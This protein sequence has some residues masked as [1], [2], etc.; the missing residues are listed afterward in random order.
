MSKRHESDTRLRPDSPSFRP[1]SAPMVHSPPAGPS[2]NLS[3]GIS[4]QKWSPRSRGARTRFN[5]SRTFHMANK[6]SKFN[7]KSTFSPSATPPTDQVGGTVDGA[8]TDLVPKFNPLLADWSALYHPPLHPLQYNLYAPAPFRVR[9]ALEEHQRVADDL[10]IPAKLRDE[11]VERNEA[12]LQVLPTSNLP[13]FVHVY[14][15]LLPLDL[16]PSTSHKF[17]EY[18]YWRYKVVSATDGRT[19]CLLRIG[20]FTLPKEYS[21]QA[22]NKWKRLASAGVVG[23]VEAF[24]TLAFGDHS[25]VVVHE[26][27]PLA[28]PVC[29]VYEVP[30]PEGLMWS[31]AAQ[32]FGAVQAIHKQKLVARI[33]DSKRVLVTSKDRLRIGSCG[34]LDIVDFDEPVDPSQDWKDVGAVLKDIGSTSSGVFNYS[35]DFK[36]FIESLDSG[37]SDV[38]K[39]APHLWRVLDG[40]LS[41]VDE[42]ESQLSTE[43]ENGRLVRLLAKLEFVF[44]RPEYEHDPEW[45]PQGSKYPLRLFKDFVFHQSDD[46]NHPSMDLA[47]TITYLNKLDAGID[48][49]ILLTSHDHKSRII[50]SYKD[51]KLQIE[52]IFRELMAT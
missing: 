3:P 20:G 52:Q 31:L 18:P 23:V 4:G 2:G 22:V 24:T 50:V 51:L 21:L 28:R 5:P 48:E 8:F 25:L 44:D 17:G 7:P 19:Y 35:P 47:R 49:N 14:H 9:P 45:T 11:L 15:S 26:Y 32:L 42:L 10:F 37:H 1:A 41:F 43:L 33:I 13:D 29:E 6:T 34:V 46:Q 30:P 39:L 27:W 12:I 38:E 36:A 16:K 40:S